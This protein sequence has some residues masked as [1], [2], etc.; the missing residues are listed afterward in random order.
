MLSTM[1][2]IQTQAF[3]KVL[4]VC[5]FSLT[6]TLM[7]AWHF[8]DLFKHRDALSVLAQAV[9]TCFYRVNQSF[10]ATMI[11][12]IKS[13]YLKND[14]TQLTNECFK[15]LN[16]NGKSITS[17]TTAGRKNLE[18][19]SSEVVWFHEKLSKVIAPFLIDPT[20]DYQV[21]SIQSKF[22][23]IE[24][25]K[26]DFLDRVEAIQSEQLQM[27]NRDELILLF[28][29][30]AF[31]LSVFSL[32]FI[33][34]GQMRM[35]NKIE[36][37]ALTLLNVGHSQVGAKVE[38][39]ILNILK[40]QQFKISSQV[41]KDYHQLV[42]NQMSGLL[43]RSPKEAT[44]I[45]VIETSPLI[46]E[47]MVENISSL[48]ELK[49]GKEVKSILSNWLQQ[50]E[51]FLISSELESD[52]LEIDQEFIDQL[53]TNIK[54]YFEEKE[55]KHFSLKGSKIKNGY[56]LRFDVPDILIN[57]TDLNYLSTHA[58]QGTNVSIN[59][60]LVKELCLENNVDLRLVNIL[61]THGKLI[62]AE[63]VLEFN[64]NNHVDSRE[65]LNEKESER[66]MRSLVNLFKGKKNQW[67]NGK[68]LT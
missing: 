33:L 15:D 55:V 19:L 29:F 48:T 1:K 6:V 24:T 17:M 11:K 30:S 53:F 41:F 18:E 7:T 49:E 54:G 45:G 4:I 51:H 8:G 20:K 35:R 3:E 28:S 63:L 64:Q 22:E 39:L 40:I 36:H 14:F 57:S 25:V 42:L 68:E 16:K 46:K 9:D 65:D 31:I 12:D 43:L 10:T 37:H 67:R 38:E 21:Q 23:K 56:C 5:G 2:K 13:H 47:E 62:G 60:V 26:F 34:V 52:S 27:M 44:A 59:L 61:N 58:L 32:S 50:N 66:P